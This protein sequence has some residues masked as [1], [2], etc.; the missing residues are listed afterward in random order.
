[1]SSP[2]EYPVRIANHNA[3]AATTAAAAGLPRVQKCHAHGL[4]GEKKA[5]SVVDNV[6][7][8]GCA[9]ATRKTWGRDGKWDKASSWPLPFF[10]R[11]C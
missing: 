11:L 6:R 5:K 2:G 4:R 7:S 8:V 10:F 1:M 3:E 9:L